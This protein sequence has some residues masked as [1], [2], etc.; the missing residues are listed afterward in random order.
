MDRKQFTFYESFFKAIRRIRKKQDRADA[1]D[2]IASYALYGLLPDMEKLPDSAAIAFDLIR[3]TLDASRRKAESGKRGG[4]PKQTESKAEANRK[5]GKPERD[6]EVEI[7]NEVEVEGEVEGEN[8]CY[9]DSP[10]IGGEQKSPS[11]AVADYLDRVNPSASP[12]SLEEL[13][14]F[15][16][17]MGDAVCRRAIDIALDSRKA[18][19]PYIRAILRDKQSRGV[20]CLADWDRLDNA[21]EARIGREKPVSTPEEQEKK[22]QEDM[23]RMRRLMEQMEE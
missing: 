4:R 6:N 3:P 17:T 7:E 2:A 22:A 23:E 12:A 8:E 21:R 19:W 5:R 16:E 20:R 10:P 1:Y 15:A 11:A 9:K 18:T 14:A 13:R